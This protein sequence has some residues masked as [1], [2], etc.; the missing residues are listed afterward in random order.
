MLKKPA[1]G[2]LARHCRLTVSAARTTLASL[3]RDAVRLP[4]ALFGAMRVL[5]RRGWVGEM[6]SLFEHPEVILALATKP[7]NRHAG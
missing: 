6:D 7:A 3:I 1:S 4:A 2:V 5:A